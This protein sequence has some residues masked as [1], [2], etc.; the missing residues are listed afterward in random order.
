MG[1]PL[2]PVTLADFVPGAS[3][4]ETHRAK[5]HSRKPAEGRSPTPPVTID[6]KVDAKAQESLLIINHKC[7]MVQLSSIKEFNAKIVQMLETPVS[8]LNPSELKKFL[9]QSEQRVSELQKS[10]AVL[11]VTTRS[12]IGEQARSQRIRELLEGDPFYSESLRQHETVLKMVQKVCSGPTL[13]ELETEYEHFGFLLGQFNKFK[14]SLE[15]EKAKITAHQPIL[16]ATTTEQID[17]PKLEASVKSL[18]E[19]RNK[20]LEKARYLKEFIPRAYAQMNHLIQRFE[21]IFGQ[22]KLEDSD[23][24]FQRSAVMNYGVASD[25][26]EYYELM[27]KQVQLL[28]GMVS[29]YQDTWNLVASAWTETKDNI[30]YLSYIV[31]NK[32]IPSWSITQGREWVGPDALGVV[33]FDWGLINPQ[34]ASGSWWLPWATSSSGAASSTPVSAAP[35][36]AV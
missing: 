9:H 5:R 28:K 20:L 27:Y 34:T 16:K 13:A 19:A 31:E 30:R 7:L 11:E 6:S 24:L 8:A 32:K 18:L 23:I 10:L 1:T 4:S 26:Y 33:S 29:G 14:V 25:E 15:A 3:A 36:G 12:R 21:A 17:F 22:K 35:S 2:P